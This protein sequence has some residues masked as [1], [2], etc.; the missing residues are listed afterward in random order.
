MARLCSLSV[1]PAAGAPPRTRRGVRARSAKRSGGRGRSTCTPG[2][3]LRG[4]GGWVGVRPPHARSTG[5]G[6]DGS[7]R[8]FDGV[9]VGE[10]ERTACRDQTDDHRE[11]GVRDALASE[12]GLHEVAAPC[13]RGQLGGD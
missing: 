3:H 2:F 9:G 11:Y 10:R 13:A 12:E 5:P 8:L 1:I 4:R 7:G 6:R